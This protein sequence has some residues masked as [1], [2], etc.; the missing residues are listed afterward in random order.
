MRQWA[1]AKV[2]AG[3]GG[4]DGEDEEGHP[5]DGQQGLAADLGVGMRVRSQ[6]ILSA[7]SWGDAPRLE[8]E[9]EDAGGIVDLHRADL[10]HGH[11]PSW[12]QAVTRVVTRLRRTH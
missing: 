1:P 8:H 7:R 9:D 11:P 5:L 10:V 3:L 4:E 12:T 2:A 6:A